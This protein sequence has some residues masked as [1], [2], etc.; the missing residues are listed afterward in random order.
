VYTCTTPESLYP[1]TPLVP[2]E[3]LY[4]SCT[5]VPLYCSCTIAILLY[6]CT[7][8]V[9][10][11]TVLYYSCTRVPLYYL[12]TLVPL[13]HPVILY[14][15]SVQL[16]YPVPLYVSCNPVHL[17]FSSTQCTL[18]PVPLYYTRTSVLTLNHSCTPLPQYYFCT[19][20]LL[21]YPCTNPGPL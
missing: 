6:L 9:P 4:Y 19:H 16:Y 21:L 20:V 14:L 13:Y 2:L 10:C 15:Y 17:N 18:T 5:S 1:C 12:C 11:T 8:P 3:L 7:S